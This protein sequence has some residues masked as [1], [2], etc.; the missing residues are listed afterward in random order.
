M[1]QITVTLDLTAETLEVLKLLIPQASG[2]S[3]AVKGDDVPGQMTLEEFI[4][5]NPEE[6]EAPGKDKKPAKRTAAKDKKP[7]PKEAPAEEEKPAPAPAPVPAPEVTLTDVRSVALKLSKAG[8]QK[9]LKEIFAKYG[10]DKLSGIAA[11]NYAALLADL[12]E[13]A[14]G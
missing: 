1:A 8:R 2:K 10:A 6:T 5:D 9:E 7:A 11:E 3:T 13:K 12:E 4:K 14:N